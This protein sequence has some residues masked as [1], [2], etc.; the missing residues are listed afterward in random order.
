MSNA[1]HGQQGI[2]SRVRG[3]GW[4]PPLL[5]FSATGFWLAMGWQAAVALLFGGAMVA[6]T[7]GLERWQRQRAAR[8]A[9]NLPAK[10]LR[11]LYRCAVE[12]LVVTLALFAAGFG[13]MALHPLPLLSG[14][15]LARLAMFHRFYQESSLRRQHG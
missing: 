10:N 14:Y 5:L 1:A 8:I 11:Y 13:L 4:A 9:G 2:G 15:T 12:R 3:V 6:A 7:G